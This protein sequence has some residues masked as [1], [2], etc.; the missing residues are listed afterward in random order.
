MS[1]DKF[2]YI[3]LRTFLFPIRFLTFRQI[4]WLGNKFG[5]LAYHLHPTFRK[6]ALSNLSLA[7]SLQLSRDAIIQTAKES[8]QNLLI[9]CLEYEKFSSLKSTKNVIICKNPELAQS[10]INKGQGIIFFCGHQANWE[11]LFLDGTQKMPGIAIGRPIKNKYLYE[12]I[13]SIREKFGGTIITPKKALKEGLRGLRQGKFLGI[14][15]DQ[16]MPDSGYFHT[17]LG[18]KAWTSPAPALLSYKTGCPIMVATT[19]RQDGKYYIT[20][21]DPIW[22]DQTQS[23]DEQMPKLMDKTLEIFERSVIK[24]PGQWLWQHNRFKQETPNIVYYKYRFD[25]ILIL[26]PK[27]EEKFNE[28]FPVASLFKEIYPKAFLTFF[29]P[30]KYASKLPQNLKVITYENCNELFIKDFQYKLVL[31]FTKNST[32]KKHFLK[33][34]AQRVICFKDILNDAKPYMDKDTNYT[35]IEIIKRAICRPGTLWENDASKPLLHRK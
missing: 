15:G 25:S 9:T 12:W 29:A 24:H 31:N 5:L 34:A 8:F 14:V 11:T 23:L 4:H 28:F 32:I 16:G 22:P 33:Q 17:F 3:L 20:Y 2:L 19:V 21:S 1:K 35:L 26:F 27:D 13:I 18:Q 6:R 30:E 7:K 10:F